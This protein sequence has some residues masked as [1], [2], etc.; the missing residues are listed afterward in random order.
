MNSQENTDVQPGLGREALL[1]PD[2]LGG[3]AALSG[4][5]G[6]FRVLP[7]LLGLVPTITPTLSLLVK[8]KRAKASFLPA[9]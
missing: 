9:L 6:G 4:H 2:T 8:T 1:C 5:T 3:D 7:R